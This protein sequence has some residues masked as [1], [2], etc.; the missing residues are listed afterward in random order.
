VEDFI[1]S[2]RGRLP[3]FRICSISW[4]VDLLVATPSDACAS[5]CFVASEPPDPSRWWKISS[6]LDV[7]GSLFVESVAYPE[8]STCRCMA[9]FEGILSTPSGACSSLCFVAY[10]PS[11]RWKISSF[12]GVDNSSFSNVQCRWRVLALL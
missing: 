2:G 1:I 12:L 10:E 11:R 5:L 3:L 4:G 7:D 9:S 6:S 8:P